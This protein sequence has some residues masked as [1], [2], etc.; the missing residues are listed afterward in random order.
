MNPSMSMITPG[1]RDLAVSVSFYEQGPG[2]PRME[3]LTEIVFFTLNGTWLGLYPRGAL[4]EDAT[5]SPEGSS[6]KRY[7]Q[8]RVQ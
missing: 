1:V 7:V 8:M 3:S 4:A 2:F 5:D 6:F